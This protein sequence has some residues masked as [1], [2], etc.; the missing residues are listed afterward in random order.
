MQPL[1]YIRMS[2]TSNEHGSLNRP[3]TERLAKAELTSRCTEIN[4]DP[5]RS[6]RAA[7]ASHDCAIFFRHDSKHARVS[8][9]RCL[10]KVKQEYAPKAVRLAQS[11][12]PWN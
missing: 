8:V 12:A 4:L 10:V 11:R 6:L 5:R 1:T 9:Y 7:I 2:E 3:S